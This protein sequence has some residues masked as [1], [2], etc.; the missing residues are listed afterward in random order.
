VGGSTAV[1]GS[2]VIHMKT[3]RD[4]FVGW[5]LTFVVTVPAGMALFFLTDVLF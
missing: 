5:M 1:Q 2:G 3:V 4:I